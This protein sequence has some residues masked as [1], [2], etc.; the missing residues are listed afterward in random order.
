MLTTYSFDWTCS[1][2]TPARHSRIYRGLIPLLVEG[3]TKETDFESTEV[4]LDASFKTTIKRG[5]CKKGN[6]ITYREV[7]N[8]NLQNRELL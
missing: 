4:I 7:I 1:D 2:E 3:S 8:R 6:T 5:L